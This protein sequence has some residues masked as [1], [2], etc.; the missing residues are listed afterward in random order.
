MKSWGGREGVGGK[1]NW[2]SFF[3][4]NKRY[5][6][7]EACA[8]VFYLFLDENRQKKKKKKLY[9]IVNCTACVSRARH[10]NFS[11]FVSTGPHSC[12]PVSSS[13]TDKCNKQHL[14]QAG[15]SSTSHRVRWPLLSFFFSQKEKKRNPLF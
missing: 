4:L 2:I 11:I 15:I 6:Y 9:Q 10:S 1:E 5:S 13:S 12:C 3:F 14:L 7:Y 8:S